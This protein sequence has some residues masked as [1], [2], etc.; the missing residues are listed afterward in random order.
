MKKKKGLESREYREK[1]A[2]LGSEV[3]KSEE[4]FVIKTKDNFVLGNEKEEKT[5][6]YKEKKKK[7]RQ[8]SIKKRVERS[9]LP[10]I[11]EEKSRQFGKS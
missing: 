4:R 7:K 8:V 11:W 10:A 9:Q 5:R 1:A 2:N 6:E 3:L